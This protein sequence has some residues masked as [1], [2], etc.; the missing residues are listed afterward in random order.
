MTMYKMVNGER[1]EMTPDEQSERELVEAKVIE[2]SLI[3]ENEKKRADIIQ[4]LY[5]LDCDSIRAL[6]AISSG[7]STEYDNSKIADI[8]IKADELRTEL[9]NLSTDS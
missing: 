3:Y 5:S 4:K 2:D 6:R 8:N 9:S 1:V 7:T